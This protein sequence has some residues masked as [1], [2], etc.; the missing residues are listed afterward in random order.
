M[1]FGEMLKFF[2]KKNLCDFSIE[3]SGDKSRLKKKV[4]LPSVFDTAAQI[5][6]SAGRK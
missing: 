1:S 2:F 5:L 6:V 3:F 4:F